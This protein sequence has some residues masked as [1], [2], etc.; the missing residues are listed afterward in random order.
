MG[1]V[2][3]MVAS[4]GQEWQHVTQFHQHNITRAAGVRWALT[5]VTLTSLFD[6]DLGNCFGLS[7]QCLIVRDMETL[8]GFIYEALPGQFPNN[9]LLE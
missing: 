2:S 3:A 5:K 4:R 7:R 1:T 8:W 6:T 9:S